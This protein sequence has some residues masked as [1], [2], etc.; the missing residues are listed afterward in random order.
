ML[1]PEMDAAFEMTLGKTEAAR[2]RCGDR[3][4][5]RCWVE[6]SAGDSVAVC[7]LNGADLAEVMVRTGQAGDCPRFSRGCHPAA[8]AQAVAAGATISGR[9]RLP[10][11]CRRR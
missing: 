10:G 5:H 4:H 3:C 8:E 6:S 11:Y 1:W 7:Y 9:Y 2:Q